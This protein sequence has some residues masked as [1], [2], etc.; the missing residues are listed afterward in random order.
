METIYDITDPWGGAK[1][2]S[3]LIAPPPAAHQAGHLEKSKKKKEKKVLV[4]PYRCV[5]GYCFSEL[6]TSVKIHLLLLL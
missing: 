3:Q 4:Q 5:K 2:L 1:Q 6:S